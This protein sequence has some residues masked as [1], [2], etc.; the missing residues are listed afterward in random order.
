[1]DGDEEKKRGRG[2]SGELNGLF[3]QENVPSSEPVA[4][5]F[6]ALKGRKERVSLEDTG[7]RSIY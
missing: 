7:R 1:M 4:G 2:R 5:A 3:T 6:V